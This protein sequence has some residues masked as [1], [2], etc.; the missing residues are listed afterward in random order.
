MV[1]D[2]REHFNDII[3]R[4]GINFRMYHI[5]GSPQLCQELRR[6]LAV[7]VSQDGA[8]LVESHFGRTSCN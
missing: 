2:S 5:L 7:R 6:M 4:L 8:E 1:T 3:H